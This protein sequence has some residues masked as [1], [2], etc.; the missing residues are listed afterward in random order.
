MSTAMA[1]EKGGNQEVKRGIAR[2]ET[3]T[4]CTYSLE[5]GGR[6]KRRGKEGG[7]RGWRRGGGGGRSMREGK[8]EGKGRV[9]TPDAA[10]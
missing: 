2:R 6:G 3:R 1:H 4:T 9:C 8:E 10:H 7:G 5:K